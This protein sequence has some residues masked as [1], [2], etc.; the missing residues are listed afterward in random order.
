MQRDLRLW[1]PH[2]ANSYRMKNE[3]INA[4]F[5]KYYVLSVFNNFFRIFKNSDANPS[6][7]TS[8]HSIE[9]PIDR[10]FQND[11][12]LQANLKNVSLGP[13]VHLKTKSNVFQQLS[14]AMKMV[15]IYI[16]LIEEITKMSE[17]GSQPSFDLTLTSD[18]ILPSNPQQTILGFLTAIGFSIVSNMFD[19]A[20]VT[21]LPD[22][23][24][25]FQAHWEDGT[26]ISWE[27]IRRRPLSEGI[28]PSNPRLGHSLADAGRPLLRDLRR[29]QALAHVGR[30]RLLSGYPP[31]W[32]VLPSAT[33]LRHRVRLGHAF[34]DQVRLI[35]YRLGLPSMRIRN[36][37][38][39]TLVSEPTG[40]LSVRNQETNDFAFLLFGEHAHKGE[41]VVFEDHTKAKR[42]LDIQ[43]YILES[44]AKDLH[45]DQRGEIK[46][47]LGDLYQFSQ[48][49]LTGDICTSLILDGRVLWHFEYEDE[50]VL[51]LDS[52]PL[53][54][55]FTLRQNVH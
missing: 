49:L 9:A 39:G 41:I 2:F 55:D 52:D 11:A 43:A 8:M 15:P 40:L 19:L 5:H 29:A 47:L 20:P 13:L 30:V 27:A 46:S 54:S 38:I 21:V 45:Y 50:L 1:E 23:G 25:T 42:D 3:Q 6:T 4:I 35:S 33:R 37:Q 44:L 53:P 32:R 31:K 51:E 18:S 28:P 10:S 7:T 48:G 12:K 34:A 22:Q 14:H 26:S 17:S 16:S 36:C 24:D